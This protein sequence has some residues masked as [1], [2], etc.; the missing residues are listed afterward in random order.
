VSLWFNPGRQ[1]GLYI[2][3]CLKE[4]HSAVEKIWMARLTLFVYGTLKR[5]GRGHALLARQQ[6]LGVARTTPGYRLVQGPWYPCLIKDSSGY[7]VEGELWSVDEAALAELDAYEGDA[8]LFE[9]GP[10]AME[11]ATGSVVAYFF[12][13]P[14]AGMKDC[15]PC[16]HVGSDG[17]AAT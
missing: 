13:G 12:R 17:D 7:A 15:G 9:R 3:L 11:N 16:W 2:E 5:G 14:T 4:P 6:Y 10:I 1:F 8:D